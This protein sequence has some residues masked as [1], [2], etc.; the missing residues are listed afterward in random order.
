M[1]LTKEKIRNMWRNYKSNYR[2]F[3][4]TALTLFFLLFSIFYFKYA[5][6]R[7]LECFRNAC[8]TGKFYFSKL[9]NLDL[10]GEITVIQ[11]TKQPFRL[12][13]GIPVTWEDFS[14][15]ISKYFTVFIS[16]E[17]FIG[18]I[19]LLGNIL[20]VISNVIMIIAP[21]A[22]AIIIYNLLRKK[23]TNNNY[24]VDSKALKRFKKFEDKYVWPLKKW[25]NEF[26]TFL[27]ENNY[28]LKIWLVIFL[29]QFNFFSI[30]FDTF[31]YYIYFV[32]SFDR[33]SIYQELIRLLMDLSVVI[34]FFPL[35]IWILIG[36]LVLYLIRSKIGLKNLNHM[37][38]MDRGFINERPIV[39]MLCGTMGSKKTTMITDIALSQEIML[40]DKAFE[41]IQEQDLK[42]PNFPWINFE[43]RI[44]EAIEEHKI[45]NLATAKKWI[46]EQKTYFDAFPSPGFIFG[47]DINKYKLEYDNNLYLENIWDTLS[48]YCQLYFIYL[49]QSS[50]II[51][52]YSI[53]SDN[54]L[55]DLGNFPLWNNDLFT[56]ES[57]NIEE[58][59]HSHIL[60][61]DSLRLGKKVLENNQLSD[62]F[63][64]GV[65][66]ITEIGKERGNSL[67]NNSV[68]KND[69]TANQ[70]N[71][72]FNSWLK[73]VRHS[74]TVDNFPFVKVIADEQRPESWGADARDL[75]EIVYIDEC[76]D[77]QLAMPFFS[78][79]DLIISFFVDKFS[80]HYYNFRFERG[81]NTLLMY[82]Y[83]RFIA[84]LHNYRLRIYNKYG[85]YH[86]KMNVEKGTMDEEPK[87]AKY[88][89]M[90]KKI[91]SK[92]F[93]TDC[94]SD[95][96]TE[97]ALRSEFGL[98]DLPSFEKEKASFEEMLK[99]NSYFFNDLVKIKNNSN[100]DKDK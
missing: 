86:V 18:Y 29:F 95:F 51:S 15:K 94:F 36:Y 49:I 2:H 87:K 37:E 19:T 46:E 85:F 75:C 13:L 93:S 71:D 4:C 74:A 99:E 84:F 6:P 34:D 68:K 67:E 90:F 88:F 65:I 12:P 44:K 76:S 78:L 17:N 28:Y 25:V 47:Y 26:I 91:Y 100:D 38:M 57:I 40:R 60:D 42:F 39:L 11:F 52:N 73:M 5:M 89:L 54:E 33:T 21:I 35:P 61:F 7:F 10:S 77:M 45:Y 53:R 41:K 66:N 43:L 24:N 20:L 50:L 98:D 56:K 70:K 83:H 9:F 72:L 23:K 62:S 27:R 1:Q 14:E 92:R 22:A 48:T 97:K 30:I 69:L 8:T 81:D 16:Q 96:F 79:E 64:F 59:N 58:S 80:D 3:I 63:E 31:N 55:M 82:L 32:S